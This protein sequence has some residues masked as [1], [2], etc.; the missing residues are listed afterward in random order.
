MPAPIP[1]SLRTQAPTSTFSVLP[2]SPVRLE[3]IRNSLTAALC[4]SCSYLG[5]PDSRLS[6]P[7]SS[8]S[9][10]AQAVHVARV[11]PGSTP[12]ARLTQ[13]SGM[14]LGVANA[15]SSRSAR[16]CASTSRQPSYPGTRVGSRSSSTCVERKPPSARMVSSNTCT[17]S[18][19]SRERLAQ[20]HCTARRTSCC[21]PS[22]M[23]VSSAS[24]RE[25][26]MPPWELLPRQLMGR[27]SSRGKARC[28]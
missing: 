9:V 25:S 27:R 21:S 22:R 19:T 13:E 2:S 17:R 7:N 11:S 15:G 20:S 6:R 3:R 1:E 8:S 18:S 23:R 10:P 14:P 28:I 24:M 12:V 5:S 4:A 16:S 26:A